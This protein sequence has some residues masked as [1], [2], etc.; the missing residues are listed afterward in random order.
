MV[1]R[2]RPVPIHL[3]AGKR[4]DDVEGALNIENPFDLF[5]L[6]EADRAGH[7][8]GDKVVLRVRPAENPDDPAGGLVKGLDRRRHGAVC[9]SDRLAE[10]AFGPVWINLESKDIA[11][12][13]TAD[14][15]V[16]GAGIRVRLKLARKGNPG[17]TEQKA[18]DPAQQR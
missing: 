11:T 6:E 3:V 9:I 7:A 8:S 12:K 18:E 1:D 16:A 5:L 4:V 17:R 15:H 13:L 14:D 10:E 2:R